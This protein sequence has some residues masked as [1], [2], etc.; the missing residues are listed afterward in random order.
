M[1]FGRVK[2]TMTDSITPIHDRKIRVAWV[3]QNIVVRQLVVREARQ[4]QTMQPFFQLLSGEKLRTRS[5][6]DRKDRLTG[7]ERREYPQ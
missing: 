4:V 5:A 3:V 1:I 7:L 2:V 6:H